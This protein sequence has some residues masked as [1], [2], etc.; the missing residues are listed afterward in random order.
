[1]NK[2]HKR[3]IIGLLFIFLD[4]NIFI[5]LLPD[6]VGWYMIALAFAKAKGTAARWGHW[7]AVIASILSIPL[8]LNG[9][10]TL[11]ES[12]MPLWLNTI[13]SIRPFAEF[14]AFAAFFLISDELLERQKQSIFSYVFL[15]YLLVWLLWQHLYKHFLPDTAE[16][17]TLILGI[18]GFV[19]MFCFLI[20]V[21]KRKNE[22]KWKEQVDEL[23]LEA[24]EEALE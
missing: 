3:W 19:L 9:I 18:A 5:D 8:V 17:T 21:I 20:N 23:L 1:M 15:I 12:D 24:D 6:F 4:I 7:G 22:E 13:L 14:L 16:N 11:P 2:F 10:A